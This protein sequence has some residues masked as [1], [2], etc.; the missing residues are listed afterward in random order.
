MESPNNFCRLCGTVLR[1]N[2]RRWLFSRNSSGSRPDL[3]VVL[4]YV[5][6]R[7]LPQR[8]D[9]RGEFLCG[10]CA[11]ALGRVYHFDTVIARVQALSIDRLQRLL[12]EKDQLARC[13]RHIYA[14]RF[15]NNGDSASYTGQEISASLA[16]LPQVQ[17]QRLLQDDMALSEYECW[18]DTPNSSQPGT[19][20]RNHQC[21]SCH[22]L[23]V[24]DF[25]YEWVCRT[26]RRL[27]TW[28][29]VFALCRDKSQS[30]PTVC[31]AGSQASLRSP[32]LGDVESCSMLS[33]DTL[34]ES[35]LAWEALKALR[36]IRRKRLRVPEGSKI[37]VLVGSWRMATPQR[38]SPVGEEAYDELMDEFLPLESKLQIQRSLYQ[39]LERTFNNLKERLEAAEGERESFQEK[40]GE[41]PSQE[42]GIPLEKAVNHQEQLIHQLTRCLQSK[43][44]VLQECLVILLSLGSPG[45]NPPM[46][47]TLIK[48]MAQRLKDRDRALEKT[49]SSHFSALKSVHRQLRHLQEA[50]K[51]K[52]ADMAR[53][54]T[55]LRTE[56]ETMHALRELLHQKDREIQ[57]LES[58]CASAQ[59]FWRLQGQTLLFTLKEK[60][61]LIKALQEALASSTKDVEALANSLSSSDFAPGLLQ[62]IQEKEDLLAQALAEQTRVQA[63]WPRQ[64]QV[65]EDAA[66]AREHKLQEQL[67]QQSQDAKE[68][69]QEI[70]NLRRHLAQAEA[71][72]SQG[73]VLLEERCTELARLRGMENIKEHALE[74]ALREGEEK[75]RILQ[76][77]QAHWAR[78]RM[79][80]PTG[81]SN[82]LLPPV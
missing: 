59:E 32:S 34:P 57:R 23:R 30:M 77:L 3:L 17:Y 9:G 39:D 75:D 51:D 5:L 60:E 8:G 14:R 15:P 44:E 20:C 10:K 2:H 54:N 12:S 76:R 61:A 74:K 53:L 16:D 6:D 7:E 55:S 68:R 18:A 38:D 64:L 29:P 78:G 22:G 70:A 56:E 11:Q 1:G 40:Q 45:V 63:Q 42:A 62:R 41:A 46:L 58:L 4:S 52:D 49:L 72:V 35:D 79:R 31:C 65:V 66:T 24:D 82:L 80:V 28:S 37:P 47:E 19:P 67:R 43:E 27:G 13:L 26:P 71:R 21:H 81:Q 50:L 48:Q 73:A 25:N 36:G 33:L 69:G